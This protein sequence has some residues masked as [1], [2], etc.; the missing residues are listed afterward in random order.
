LKRARIRR[1]NMGCTRNTAARSKRK[2]LEVGQCTETIG[3]R[4]V[5]QDRYAAFAYERKAMNVSRKALA[6]RMGNV[7]HELEQGVVRAI[8]GMIKPL[9][10][11]H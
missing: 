11:F 8:D 5:L 3:D 7:F 9:F 1:K 10:G 6:A 2:A 4:L